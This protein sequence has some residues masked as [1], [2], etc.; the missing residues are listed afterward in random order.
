MCEVCAYVVK[1]EQTALTFSTD[2]PVYFFLMFCFAHLAVYA[3][4]I[5]MSWGSPDITLAY[6]IFPNCIHD[7]L[8]L[9]LSHQI[10][11]LI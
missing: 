6:Q 7:K 4:C 10:K 1:Y 3:E 11:S 2:H 9:K 8:V 5:F